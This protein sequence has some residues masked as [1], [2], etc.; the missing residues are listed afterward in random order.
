MLSNKAH[1]LSSTLS[2]VFVCLLLFN[3]AHAQSLNPP[4]LFCATNSL[5]GDVSLTW[6]PSVNPCGPF[7]GYEIWAATAPDGPYSLLST[8]LTEASSTFTHIGAD[9]VTS[10]WYYYLIPDY[11]CPGFAAPTSDTLDNRDPVPPIIDYVTVVPTGAELN[12]LPSPSPETTSYI[13]YRQ[14]VG[15]TPIDTVYGRF[16]TVYTDLGAAVNT[17]PE[18]YSIAALDSCRTL[19]LFANPAHTTILLQQDLDICGNWNLNWNAY[20]EWPGGIASHD[21]VTS[22]NGAP[23]T[24]VASVPGDLFAYNL[25]VND[26]DSV[27]VSVHALRG[28]GVFSR[29]NTHCR[30]ITK[31]QPSRFVYLRNATMAASDSAVVEWYTDPLADGESWRLER[32][33][34]PG[35]WSIRGSGDFPVPPAG[36]FSFSD[37]PTEA[38]LY[39]RAQTED[40]CGAL[41]PSGAGRTIRLRSDAAFG[42]SNNLTWNAFELPNATVHGYDLFRLDAGIW[43]LLVTLPSTAL[44]YTDDVSAF[45]SGEG[46]FCYRIEARFTLDLPDLALTEN[47][48]SRSNETCAEQIG[49][50]FVPNAIV[51]GGSN[52]V[53]KPVILFGETGSYN[54]QVISRYGS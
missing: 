21:I 53:F 49:K 40:S 34:T 52:P 47:L 2:A 8:V 19:G 7:E 14:V 27:C 9:G 30:N 38:G 37:F 24:V 6:T 28:D 45:L 17:Q 11:D 16:N 12:W 15:F 36:F 3:N 25:A 43:T 50:V 18:T 31:V 1:T 26:G 4:E 29:S 54:L 13:I 10:T 48:T 32:G 33:G 5:S 42:L 35:P 51:P 44:Q 39:Y 46:V 41:V 23:E 22:V 20:A